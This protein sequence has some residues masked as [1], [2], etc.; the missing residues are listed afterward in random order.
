MGACAMTISFT[1]SI[2]YI[3]RLL[4]GLISTIDRC[5]TRLI[6]IQ[7]TTDAAALDAISIYNNS[8]GF[9]WTMSQI[10]TFDSIYSPASSMTSAVF[11][12]NLEPLVQTIETMVNTVKQVLYDGKSVT[13]STIS[14]VIKELDAYKGLLTTMLLTVNKVET[15]ESSLIIYI[16]LGLMAIP[17]VAIVICAAGVFGLAFSS[18]KKRCK[19]CPSFLGFSGVLAAILGSVALVVASVFLTV[20][21]LWL[22][23][24]HVSDIITSD[25]RPFLGQRKAI[26]ANQ[27]MNGTDIS[28]AL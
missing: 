17:L 3:T 27:V 11:S 16:K 28:I 21:I 4:E 1:K 26:L 8:Y 22:D 25:F 5:R 24:C 20:N 10:F 13:H 6:V 14:S 2:A 18:C 19:G 9:H 7:N 12:N 15:T 23:S